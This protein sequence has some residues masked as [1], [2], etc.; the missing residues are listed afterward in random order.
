MRFLT[1]NYF[2]IAAINFSTQV[3]LYICLFLDKNS[4]IIFSLIF[5]ILIAS[6]N[7]SGI[8]LDH[9]VFLFDTILGT[10]ALGTRLFLDLDPKP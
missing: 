9:I 7:G 3:L 10:S 2:L 8:T 6:L 4:R 5:C 1:K